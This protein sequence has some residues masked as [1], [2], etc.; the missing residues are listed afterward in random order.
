MSG[1]KKTTKKKNM[2]DP[3][4]ALH[5]VSFRPE[6]ED[7]ARELY[8]LACKGSEPLWEEMKELESFKGNPVLQ[9]KFLFAS[10]AGMNAAQ[11]KIVELI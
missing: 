4:T 2:Y 8:Q 11:K 3:F 10:H 7:L 5:P 6:L 9:K 1:T